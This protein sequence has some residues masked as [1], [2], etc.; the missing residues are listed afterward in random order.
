MGGRL[1]GGVIEGGDGGL[2]G[3]RWGGGSGRERDGFGRIGGTEG[4]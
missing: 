4:Q 1:W 3:E 2:V